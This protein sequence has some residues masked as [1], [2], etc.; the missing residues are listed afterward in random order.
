MAHFLHNHPEAIAAMDFF[1]V[2]T[3]TFGLLYCFFLISHDRRRILHCNVTRHPTSSW[4]IQQLRE[5][6]PYQ[7]APRFLLSDRNVKY[8]LCEA[9]SVHRI[10][11]EMTEGGG[12][13][14][15]LP[16]SRL[17]PFTYFLE[18]RRSSV[19]LRYATC[20]RKSG[21]SQAL[22]ERPQSENSLSSRA[23]SPANHVLL[24]I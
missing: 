21:K 24:Q 17:S 23:A 20:S 13:L 19:A 16:C 6:F 1:T 8:G 18:L 9:V 5:A 4:I 14:I 3:I 15:Y 2:P 12:L 10:G 11:S 7:S 22:P